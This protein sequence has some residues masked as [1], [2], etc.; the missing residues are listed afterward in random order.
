MWPIKKDSDLIVNP[1]A[2]KNAKIEI[3]VDLV[4]EK[5]GVKCNVALPVLMMADILLQSASGLLKQLQQQDSMIVGSNKA[6]AAGP[7]K[8]QEKGG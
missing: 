2:P 1:F 3:E 6:V 4:T 8:S 5:C 7:E